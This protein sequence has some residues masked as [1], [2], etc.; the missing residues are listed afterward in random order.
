VRHGGR[1]RSS[2]SRAGATDRG[3]RGAHA[4]HDRA[5]YAKPRRRRPTSP[6]ERRAGTNQ[7]W[8][9]TLRAKDVV[10][11]AEC[12]AAPASSVPCVPQRVQRIAFEIVSNGVSISSGCRWEFVRLCCSHHSAAGRAC[13]ASSASRD[14]PASRRRPW[15]RDASSFRQ[16]WSASPHLE[17]REGW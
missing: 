5:R 8:T 1:L 13:R 2:T 6:T 3:A 12:C 7:T 9:I 11:Q 15:V 4:A 17:S 14:G 16:S 10:Y